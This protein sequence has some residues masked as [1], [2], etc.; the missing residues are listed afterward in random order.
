MTLIL[1]SL[2]FFWIGSGVSTLYNMSY[3]VHEYIHIHPFF[4][5]LVWPYVLWKIQKEIQLTDLP[6]FQAKLYTV[7]YTSTCFFLLIVLTIFLYI[8]ELIL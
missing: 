7:G 2:A 1:L 3:F 8:I 6:L 5:V 4:Q